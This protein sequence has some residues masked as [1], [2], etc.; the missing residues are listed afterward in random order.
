MIDKTWVTN[1]VHPFKVIFA[2]VI[3]IVSESVALL[4]DGGSPQEKAREYN[5]RRS[6]FHNTHGVTR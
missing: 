6:E 4:R 3:F 2:A 5:N 1:C